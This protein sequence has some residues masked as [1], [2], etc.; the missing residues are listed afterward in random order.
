MKFIIIFLSLIVIIGILK[1]YKPYKKIYANTITES[2]SIYNN[3]ELFIDSIKSLLNSI[4][5]SLFPKSNTYVEHANEFAA[6]TNLPTNTTTTKSS[7]KDKKNDNTELKKIQ[8]ELKGLSELLNKSNKFK[9]SELKKFAHLL[10]H[11]HIHS[12]KKKKNETSQTTPETSQTTPETSGTHTETSGTHTE[13]SGTHTETPETHTETPEEKQNET[14]EH[15]H[16]MGLTIKENDDIIKHIQKDQLKL[17]KE[18]N[19]YIDNMEKEKKVK[20]K[21]IRKKRDNDNEYILKTA[22]KVCPPN[23]NM[24]DY[25][26]KKSI[27]PKNATCISNNNEDTSSQQTADSSVSEP[28]EPSIPLPLPMSDSPQTTNSQQISSTEIS[29]SPQTTNS[30]QTSS[31]PIT[32]SSNSSSLYSLLDNSSDTNSLP[33]WSNTFA[34]VTPN[35]TITADCDALGS[36]GEI[37]QC[38]REKD[39]RK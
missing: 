6:S 35:T 20:E 13:T 2:Y 11:P 7:K 19:S 8:K 31:T 22:I 3:I 30:Q 38:K 17:I 33:S 27:M 21:K 37:S 29:D 14:C 34:K 32:S 9:Y 24:N 18:M 16:N 23:A 5:T 28:T 25:V 36:K 10:E 15:K 12:S 39:S 26:L 1:E 4:Y